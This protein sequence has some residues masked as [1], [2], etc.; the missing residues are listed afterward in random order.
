LNAKNL[1]SL[2]RECTLGMVFS[3]TNYSLIPQEMMA[4]GLPVIEMDGEN[5][6]KTFPKDSVI[7]AK[8]S[9]ESIAQAISS[10]LDDV[11]QR[12]KI[13]KNALYYVNSLSWEKSSKQI[14]TI[15]KNSISKSK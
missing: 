5:T 8:P 7:L 10:L 14:E 15:L 6:R 9:P 4:C 13:S 1:G 11:D 12:N 3:S 2:Y